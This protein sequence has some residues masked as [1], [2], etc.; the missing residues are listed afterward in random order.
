MAKFDAGAVVE[1]LE[2]TFKPHADL[3]G[4]V[5]EPNDRQIAAFQ[6]AM[7]DEII[8]A[9]RELG[10]TGDISIGE[11]MAALEKTD[12]TVE[13]VIEVNRRAAKIFADLCSGH[14]SQAQL[15]KVPPRARLAFF[16][17][18]QGEVLSPEALTGA[19]N[20]RELRPRSA[21]AG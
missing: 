11:F 5:P 14:P 1:A 12:Q 8:K 16:R 21:A 17:W 9:A 2:F 10:V 20:V 7:K 3:E 15:M 6:K 4:T 18:L 19:G 13:E